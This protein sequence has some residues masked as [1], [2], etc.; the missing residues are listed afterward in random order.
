MNPGSLTPVPSCL[1]IMLSCL[2]VRRIQPDI[3]KLENVGVLVGSSSGSSLQ[4]SEDHR[5]C[6][7]QKEKGYNL[8]QKEK[9]VLRKRKATHM[10][11]YMKSVLFVS[12][13]GPREQLRYHENRIKK[14]LL[15]L[16]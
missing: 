15:L 11:V 8:S 6:C 12:T 7:P 16:L 10:C 13:K 2:S 5:V 4:L 1:A 9:P 14:G 3:L